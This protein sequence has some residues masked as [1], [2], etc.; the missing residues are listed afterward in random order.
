MEDCKEYIKKPNF[1][2]CYWPLGCDILVPNNRLPFQKSLWAATLKLKATSMPPAPSVHDWRMDDGDFQLG[3]GGF[4][5]E[6]VRVWMG[7]CPPLDVEKILVVPASYHR[8]Q[9]AETS[10]ISAETQGSQREWQAASKICS[11]RN[12]SNIDKCRGHLLHCLAII[13]TA[14][15][16]G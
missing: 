3:G 16:L 2:K 6:M 13:Q 14:N 8:N 9:R 10:W 11:G 1:F 12:K 4:L 5:L 15:L 7:T